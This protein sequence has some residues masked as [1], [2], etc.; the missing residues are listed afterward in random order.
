MGQMQGG[1][2]RRD[3]VLG[4]TNAVEKELRGYEARVCHSLSSG[5]LV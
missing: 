1:G 4:V 3:G 5:A 2:K